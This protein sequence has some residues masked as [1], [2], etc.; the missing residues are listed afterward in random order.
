MHRSNYLRVETSDRDLSIAAISKIT[1]YSNMTIDQLV[2]FEGDIPQEVTID[3][4]ALVEK[5]KLIQEL[6][7]E[8]K[9]MIFKLADTLLTQ[10]KFK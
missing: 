9:S 6:E 3:D 10:K 7:P 4:K 8:E 2:N 5:V 1:K